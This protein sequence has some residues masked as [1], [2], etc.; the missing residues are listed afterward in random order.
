MPKRIRPS[1][2]VLLLSEVLLLLL[3]PASLVFTSNI[4]AGGDTPVHFMTAAAMSKNLFSFFSPV[5]WSNAA[6]GGFPLF[7]NYFPLPFALTGLLARVIPP[8]IAFKLVTLLAIIPLPAAVYMCLRRLGQGK[9][10]PGLGALL[11][12]LFLLTTGDSMWGANIRSTLAGE[13]AYGI[14]FIFYVIF[15]GKLYSDV[16]AGRSPRGCSAIE[17]LMAMCSGY[18][19]LQAVTGSC[20]FLVRGGKS[21]YW[22]RLHAVAAGLAA[23]WLLPLLWRL[24]WTSRY[25]FSWY[26][27]SWAEIFPPLLWPSIAGTAIYLFSLARGLWRSG[28]K[29][30]EIL[31]ES[32]DS[33]ELY[34][35]WQ[36][37]T[38][39]LGFSLASA[40]GLVDVRFLPF[41][42][43]TLVL[44]GAIGWGRFLS[45]LPKPGVCLA[46]FCAAGV[47]FGLAGAPSVDRWIT[48]NYSGMESKP[49]WNTFRQ[50]NDYLRGDENSART[51]FEHSH[52]NNEAGSTRAFELSPYFSGRP[53]LSG[54]Y[55]QS[56]LNA[57]F[58]YYLQSEISATPSCP[59][60]QYYYSR[61]D[62][63]GAAARLR[64]FNVSRVVAVSADMADALSFSPDYVLLKAFAPYAIFRVRGCGNSYVAPLKYYPLRI[65]PRN[66]KR[67]QFDWFRKSSLQVPLVVASRNSPGNYW[68]KLEPYDGRPGQIPALPVPGSGE[69]RAKAVLSKGRIT[70]ETSKPG[71]ALWIKVSYHP[72]WHITSG[73][74]E[75]YPVSPA[76]MLLVPKTRRVVLTFD[77]RSGIY[78]AGKAFSLLTLLVLAAELVFVRIGP[79][80]GKRTAAQQT[81]RSSPGEIKRTNF[82]YLFFFALMATVV[83]AAVSTRNYRDPTLLYRLA[84]ARFDKMEARAPIGSNPSKNPGA[85]ALSPERLQLFK[86]FDS[87]M[88]GFDHSTVFDNCESYKARL[89]AEGGMWKELRPL[90]ERYLEDN[91]DSRMYPQAL[92]R[93][94]EASLAAGGNDDAERFFRQALF[95][96]PPNEAT[97]AAGLRLEGLLGARPLMETA[98]ELFASGKYLQAYSLYEALALSPDQNTR[99]ATVLSLAYCALRL[100]RP[101]EASDLFLKWLGPN[102]DRPQSARVKADL[103]KCQALMD[104]D[105]KLIKADRG[106]RSTRA[107]PIVRLMIRAERIF[108]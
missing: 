49:L 10:I 83:I 2:L 29:L 72:D 104:Y 87:C 79:F 99:D 53:T 16:S 84:A 7:L 91:P 8:Q 77:T 107:A 78:I 55:M 51:A 94:G 96:W 85:T 13:F 26:F 102:F 32:I 19:V 31:K 82:R 21:A 106:C 67:V 81:D 60:E 30:R 88:S 20:Y 58:V 52:I 23:F 93:L 105:S 74:G 75:L 101:R 54:L 47:I 63:E 98:Q 4:T 43:I 66:W 41:A 97:K 36:L 3:F 95:T 89:M 33:P 39:L 45:R 14:S 25:S 46:G 80:T 69:V 5:E 68:K 59:L 24:P 22:L 27:H 1:I 76:F 64:L 18:P 15:I 35:F 92:F 28:K 38:A 57:P 90:L 9:N 56:A 100:N 42:Q 48:W 73:Q 108:R 103:G 50:V 40:S 34:L 44:T 37:A 70:I 71:F 6:F 17:A 86:L 11:S 62:P 12:F 61:P 65:S